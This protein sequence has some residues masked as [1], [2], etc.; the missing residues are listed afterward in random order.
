MK[1]DYM[2]L[3]AFFLL[4]VSYFPMVASGYEVTG[5]E[6]NKILV[7]IIASDDLP[8]YIQ[9]QQIWRAYMHLD[10]DHIEAYFMKGDP[11][12]EVDCKI[13][14]D[15]IW[16]KSQ[17]NIIPGVLNKTLLALEHIAGRLGE[18]DYVLRTNLSS[19][20][21]FPKLLE[22]TVSLPKDNCYFACPGT[23]GTIRF[24]SGSGLMLSPDLALQ[25]IAAKQ[26]LWN[27]SL[28]DDVCIGRFFQNR[29]P[30]IPADRFD[31]LSI[32]TWQACKERLPL[33]YHYR[34]KNNNSTLRATDEV[35]VMRQLLQLFYHVTL[36]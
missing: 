28:V 21:V 8:V 23:L 5:V 9:E 36:E 35:Y 6:R 14:G 27:N 33:K 17:E 34:V 20:Y 12:L 10:P 15:T 2:A 11:Q 26:D 31:I 25:L 13:D 1:R 30:I 3:I 7:L 16:T 18:F 22:R 4:C 19:F 24:G 32:Q 29:V